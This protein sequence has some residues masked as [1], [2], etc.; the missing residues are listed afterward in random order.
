VKEPAADDL[1]SPHPGIEVEGEVVT[2]DALGLADSSPRSSEH[3]MAKEI[4]GQLEMIASIAIQPG[5]DELEGD[6]VGPLGD[7]REGGVVA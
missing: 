2:L 1:T 3:P 4:P 6:D 5:N 7:W